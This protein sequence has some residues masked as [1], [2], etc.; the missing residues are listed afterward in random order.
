VVGVDRFGASAPASELFEH[1]GITIE[2]VSAAVLASLAE[3]QT[4]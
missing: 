3:N 1:Y 4:H 2:G